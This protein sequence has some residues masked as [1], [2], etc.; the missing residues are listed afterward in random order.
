MNTYDIMVNTGS[1]MY[2]KSH[3]R[4]T[5]FVENP[6]FLRL[7]ICSQQT[8]D[9]RFRVLMNFSATFQIVRSKV[10][11]RMPFTRGIGRGD[12]LDKHR[13]VCARECVCMCVCVCV[14]REIERV[15]ECVRE[16]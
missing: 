2:V 10:K 14:L 9:Y 15:S 5:S 3:L 6:S 4:K 13:H 12:R 1:R 16:R 7:V 11:T 8:S